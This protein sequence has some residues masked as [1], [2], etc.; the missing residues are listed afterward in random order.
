MS[1][2]NF[3]EGINEFL[4]RTEVKDVS[5]KEL[6]ELILYITSKTELDKNA[7]EKIVVAF[8]QEIRDLVIND[9]TIILQELGRFCIPGARSVFLPEKNLACLINKS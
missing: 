5:S 6:E 4:K 8:F 1:Y 9:D 7:A 3:F 2:D